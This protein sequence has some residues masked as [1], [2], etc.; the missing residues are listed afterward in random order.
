MATRPRLSARWHRT[1]TLTRCH[2]LDYKVPCSGP[3]RQ[4]V[5]IIYRNY[6]TRVSILARSQ[7]PPMYNTACHALLVHCAFTENTI[8]FVLTLLFSTAYT[9]AFVFL[10]NIVTT[11]RIVVFHTTPVTV[12]IQRWTFTEIICCR[13]VLATLFVVLGH[14]LMG[15]S[16]CVG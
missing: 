16:V 7:L 4:Y 9:G 11:F 2:R 3:F 14:L 5:I 13:T 1:I 10:R 6:I 15:M 12:T 8:L